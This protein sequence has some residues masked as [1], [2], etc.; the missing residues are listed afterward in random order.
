MRWLFRRVMWFGTGASVGFGGAVW[1]RNRIRR[2]LDRY[3]PNRVTTD[4]TTGVRRVGSD[5]R[6]AWSEGRVAMRVREAE[7]R[8]ELAPGRPPSETVEG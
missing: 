6:G 2:T 8:D 1:I 7:L 4:V 3:R 5:L